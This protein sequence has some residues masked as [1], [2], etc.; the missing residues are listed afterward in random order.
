MCLSYIVQTSTAVVRML[1][2]VTLVLFWRAAVHW[3]RYRGIC[4]TCIGQVTFRGG[5]Q[6]HFG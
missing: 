1:L 5:F 3:A 2:I 6:A 4:E